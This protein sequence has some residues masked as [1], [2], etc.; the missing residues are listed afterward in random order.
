ADKLCIVRSVTH[1]D[2][3]HPSAGYTMLTGVCHPQANTSAGA[4]GVRP[5]TTDHPH[6]GSV[7]AKVRAARNGVP[8]F[9]S[10][11][12]VIK[13]AGVNDSRGQGAGFRGRQSDPFRVE[14]EAGKSGFRV[15]EIV[16]PADMTSARLRDRRLLLRRL[17][18]AVEARAPFTDLD[19]LSEQAL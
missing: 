11:P 2:T 17:D 8:T 19:A 14:A 16:L 15:P 5:S 10:L 4:K 12:E 7:L 18:R 6:L 3:V 9:A 1:D 13:D